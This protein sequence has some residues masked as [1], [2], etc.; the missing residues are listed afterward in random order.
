M[1]CLSLAVET[2]RYSS[3]PYC[4]RVCRLCDRGE[5]EDQS[6][7]L[8][9]WCNIIQ[10]VNVCFYMC[11]YVCM[12]VCTKICACLIPL[13]TCRMRSALSSSILLLTRPSIC[14]C[15]STASTPCDRHTDLVI[16]M[17]SR[18]DGCDER[19]K[20]LGQTRQRLVCAWNAK[21]T[22]Y[23]MRCCYPRWLYKKVT[24]PWYSITVGRAMLV[25][26]GLLQ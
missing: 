3:V 24:L 2:G 18:T 10:A 12:Y 20:W 23:S 25:T 7:F 22:E 13:P 26:V 4:E 8:C 1:G 21:A 14:C 11:M 15:M 6:H 17:G 19:E 9:I 16:Y 5:V